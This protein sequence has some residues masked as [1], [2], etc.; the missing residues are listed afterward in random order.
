MTATDLRAVERYLHE[1]IPLTAHIQVGV[2]RVDDDG[3]R[4]L[5][6]L[7]PNI[8]HQQTAFGGSAASLATLACWTLI[9]FRLQQL[10]FACGIVVRRSTMQYDAPINSDFAAFCPSPDTN[11][12]SHFTDALTQHDKGRIALTAEVLCHDIST[13][14]FQGEFVALRHSG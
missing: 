11:T 14:R 7:A 12:W 3:V 5:A 8:N 6:P 1:H 2:D 9:H 10:P 13:A 4:L